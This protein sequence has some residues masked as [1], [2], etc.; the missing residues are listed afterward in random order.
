[1]KGLLERL[2]FLKNSD[3]ITE[4]AYTICR[5]TI[6]KFVSENE[7]DQYRMLIIHLAMALTRIERKQELIPPP[8]DIMMGVY[9]S[10]KMEEARGRVAW[11]NQLLNNSL[12]EEEKE[13]LY[14]HFVNVLS[15]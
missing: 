15:A 11:I 3:S 10:P 5:K 13:F 8:T 6:Q 9:R 12:P 1:M 7:A 4:K 2:E 14:L